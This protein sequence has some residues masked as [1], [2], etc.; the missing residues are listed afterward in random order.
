MHRNS[1]AK[2]LLRRIVRNRWA[3]VMMLPVVVYFAMF[4]YIPIYY[5][6]LS[7]YDYKIL[8][9]FSSSRYVGLQWFQRFFSSPSFWPITKNTILFSI[10]AI[11]WQ[12]LAPIVFALFINEVGN[13][14]VKK[15]YQTISFMP[16]FISTVIVVTIINSFISPSLGILNAWR[17]SLGLESVYYLGQP[18]Y[19]FLINYVSGVWSCMGW[20][21]VIYL[22]AL[23]G[24]DTEIY[25]AALVDGATRIKRIFHITIPSILPTIA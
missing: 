15:V 16:Y 1:N 17:R 25:E 14:K 4:K 12:T 23:S 19:F 24:I 6:R 5:M 2:Q 3:Y 11:F 20:N 13:K 8:K 9:G 18:E 10:G 22:S 7:F 21:S